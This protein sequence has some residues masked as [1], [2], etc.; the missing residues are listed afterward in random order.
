MFFD[1]ILDEKTGVIGAEGD[2]RLRWRSA[3]NKRISHAGTESRFYHRAGRKPC[4]APKLVVKVAPD[5]KVALESPMRFLVKKKRRME[6]S[7]CEQ[8]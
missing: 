5:G 8:A 1:R 2:A 3:G 6:E 4:A 7:R